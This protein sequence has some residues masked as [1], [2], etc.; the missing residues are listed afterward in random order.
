M[1]VREPLDL[2]T[3]KTI[4]FFFPVGYI[5]CQSVGPIGTVLSKVLYVFNL[6]K[7]RETFDWV[8]EYRTL[9]VSALRFSKRRRETVEENAVPIQ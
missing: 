7:K 8:E 5:V 9:M 3:E 1:A 2:A 4:G 6:K